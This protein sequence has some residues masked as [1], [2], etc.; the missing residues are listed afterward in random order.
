MH[1]FQVK[2]PI[3]NIKWYLFDAS[4]QGGAGTA[5]TK[6]THVLCKKMRFFCL[7]FEASCLQLSFSVHGCFGSLFC[8]QWE[9]FSSCLNHFLG[10]SQTLAQVILDYL[11]WGFGPQLPAWIKAWVCIHTHK[12]TEEIITPYGSAFNTA[13][14]MKPPSLLR[15]SAVGHCSCMFG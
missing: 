12:R 14:N 4:T 9:F 3:G 2:T 6:R 8:L 15:H 1:S 11:V 5:Q 13:G 10:G 7:Q